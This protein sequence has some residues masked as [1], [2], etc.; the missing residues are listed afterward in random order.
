MLDLTFGFDW[1]Y[2]MYPDDAS[3]DSQKALAA[4]NATKAS[5]FVSKV[6]K[7]VARESETLPTP[8]QV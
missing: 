2:E 1:N 6:E 8:V 7:S 5:T 3:Y 4:V